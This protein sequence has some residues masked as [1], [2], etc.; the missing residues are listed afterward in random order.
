MANSPIISL[1]KGSSI[2]LITAVA[3][4]ISAVVISMA[5]NAGI[6]FDDNT[7]IIILSTIVSALSG[8]TAAIL[9]FTK[10]RTSK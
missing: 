8:V 1:K 5:E 3:T 2:G 10:K 6:V 7:K 4:G 9:N